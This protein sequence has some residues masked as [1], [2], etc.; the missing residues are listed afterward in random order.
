MKQK[1]GKNWKD[2]LSKHEIEPRPELWQQ[3]EGTI[4]RKNILFYRKR[5]FSAAAVLLAIVGS[6]YF[7]NLQFDNG[8]FNTNHFNLVTQ[9][10]DNQGSRIQQSLIPKLQTKKTINKQGNIE[11]VNLTPSN[12]KLTYTSQEVTISDKAHKIQEISNPQELSSSE[13]NSLTPLKDNRGKNTSI[14]LAQNF[15]KPN[16]MIHRRV[17]SNTKEEE[18]TQ[19][20]TNTSQ[21]FNWILSSNLSLPDRGS[22]SQKKFIKTGT[23]TTMNPTDGINFLETKTQRKYTYDSRVQMEI[24]GSKKIYKKLSVITGLR[25]FLENGKH[26]QENTAENQTD[27][28][29]FGSYHYEQ[30]SLPIGLRQELLSKSNFRSYIQTSISFSLSQ[31]YSQDLVEKDLSK[32][33]SKEHISLGIG[34]EYKFLDWMGIFAQPSFIKG[35]SNKEDHR[36]SLKT[37]LSFHF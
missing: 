27:T 20:N 11:L 21:S 15:D 35:L 14:L 36:I 26:D 25:Y 23:I 10:D 28:Q 7:L 17:N 8:A 12:N 9:I 16:S 5:Y 2:L 33:Y 31:K 22:F 24:L 3:I 19:D 6:G 18:I 4:K 1:E 29:R 13:S 34:I 37:G 30:Y 32:L